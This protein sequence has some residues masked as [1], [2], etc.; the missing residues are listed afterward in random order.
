VFQNITRPFAGFAKL[1]PAL[2]AALICS[3]AQA[4]GRPDDSYQD[5][6]GHIGG[7]LN[8]AQG[9]FGDVVDDGLAFR[10]GATWWPADKPFGVQIEAAFSTYD[11]SS[12][13]IRDI[14]DAIEAIDPE[15]GSVSG[16]DVDDWSFSVNAIWSLGASTSQGFYLMAGIGID[17]V[18]RS[19]TDDGLVYYPP[20]C[21]PWWW[22]CTPGG[23]GPGTVVVAS[24]DSTEFS[25]NIGLGYSFP[26]GGNSLM[27]VE[28]RYK[29]VHTDPETMQVIPLTVGIR[30]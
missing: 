28:A 6:F 21:D 29:S 11:I 4:G 17:N 20:I 2:C 26:L 13:A 3:T 18:E 23:V 30:W 19:L 22:W 24:E 12:S 25:W 10:G 1:L 27:Y 5:W 16:G 7:G 9:D 14:N 15:I 8:L